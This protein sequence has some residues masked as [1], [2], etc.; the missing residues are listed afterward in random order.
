MTAHS[1]PVLSSIIKISEKLEGSK[2]SESILKEINEQLLIV[3]EFLKIDTTET[4]FFILI[5]ALENHDNE[6][7]NL[8]MIAEY[9]D[10]PFLHLLEYRYVLDLLEENSLIYMNEKKGGNSHS[11]NNGYKICASVSNGVIEGKSI[12]IPQKKEINVET[13]ISEILSICGMYKEN[14]MDSNEYFRQIILYEN[15][16]K[17]LELFENILKM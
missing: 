16:V 11:E 10:V 4:L 17:H 13:G 14:E 12:V 9:L 6:K 5:F 1:N 7:V 8:H 15:K 2:L 3:S